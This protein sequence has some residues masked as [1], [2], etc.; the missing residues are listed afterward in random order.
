[1]EAKLAIMNG[2]NT[3]TAQKIHIHL[4][5][6]F[7][8]LLSRNVMETTSI[9]LASLFHAKTMV[10]MVS[11]QSKR[12]CHMEKVHGLRFGFYQETHELNMEDGLHA[13][14]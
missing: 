4:V 10:L 7:K 13:V 12:K 8:L 9:H 2:S 6:S 3:R 11:L 14:K 5:D 1:M